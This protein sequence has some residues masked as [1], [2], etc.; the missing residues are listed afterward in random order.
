[1]GITPQAAARRSITPRDLTALPFPK[2]LLTGW[3]T[4]CDCLMLDGVDMT[5]VENGAA[6]NYA[7]NSLRWLNPTAFNSAIPASQKWAGARCARPQPLPGE[8]NDHFLVG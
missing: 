6:A 2:A 8:H 3:Q 7:A 5:F 4:S 1:M